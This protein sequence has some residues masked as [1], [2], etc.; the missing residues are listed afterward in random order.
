M[1]SHI[2]V[3][4]LNPKH[5]DALEP[6][7]NALFDHHLSI[8]AAGL[9]TI[10]REQSWP[11]RR[12]HYTRLIAGSPR[13]SIWIAT[14]HEHPVGYALAYETRGSEGPLW[15]LETLSVLPE[16]RGSGLGQTLM[17]AIDEDGRAAGILVFAV[18]VMGGNPRAR[19]F[20]L[21]AGY[22]PHTET[23]VRSVPSDK[24]PSP[25]NTPEL[26]THTLDEFRHRA[27][28]LGITLSTDPHADD[29]WHVASRTVELSRPPSSTWK[30]ASP[31]VSL[32]ESTGVTA[33]QWPALRE[34]ID[35]LA[36]AGLWTVTQTLPIDT[37]PEAD[38]AFLSRN[39]FRV[40][41]ERLIRR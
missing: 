15:V 32:R 40:S 27:E 30:T 23:W 11:F 31:V 22:L 41:T 20:Y 16:Y 1:N 38:R 28:A 24:T 35:D 21:R 7:W 33:Q 34:L 19:D 9:P 12:A 18:D 6:L 4:E 37:A 5:L 13:C 39:G 8:G 36:A 26:P 2:D 3:T 14:Q 10:P 25:P 29:T 17:A